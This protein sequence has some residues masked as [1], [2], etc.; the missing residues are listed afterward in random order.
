[1]V[2]TNQLD[3]KRVRNLHDIVRFRVEFAVIW[4]KTAISL[5]HHALQHRGAVLAALVRGHT[6]QRSAQLAHAAA[7]FTVENTATVVPNLSLDA[8]EARL[9]E[10]KETLL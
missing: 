7:S 2:N 4:L 3:T 6:P 1:M 8:L 10:R 9:T 5:V